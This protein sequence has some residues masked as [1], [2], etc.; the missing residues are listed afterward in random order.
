M[1]NAWFDLSGRVAVV[2]G[3]GANGGNGHAAALALAEHGADLL[4]CD[5]DPPAEVEPG[6]AHGCST[7]FPESPW[8]ASSTAV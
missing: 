4:I 2:T 1:S 7:T 6:L 8:S 5:R 3:G